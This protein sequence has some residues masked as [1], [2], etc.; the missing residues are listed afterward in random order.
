MNQNK[1]IYI[2]LPHVKLQDTY[3]KITIAVYTLEPSI[4]GFPTTALQYQTNPSYGGK[5]SCK[6]SQQ[7]LEIQLDGL[8]SA[9]C[10]QLG[11][12]KSA[13]K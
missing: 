6:K 1:Y 9:V 13:Y 2:L 11:I 8:H 3:H 4:F 10:I 5:L 7:L 12:Q